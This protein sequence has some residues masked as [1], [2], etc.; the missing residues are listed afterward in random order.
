MRRSHP[1]IQT[2]ILVA[3]A[4]GCTIGSGA[5]LNTPPLLG[6]SVPHSRSSDSS[7][8]VIDQCS[9]HYHASVVDHFTYSDEPVTYM[10]RYFLCAPFW[11]R[12]K[13]G[14]IFFYSGNEADVTLYL[15]ASG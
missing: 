10:Q 2:L 8:P 4:L 14:P 9:E 6:P 11:D 1:I 5:A 12:K 15:N 13:D 3:V 7:P